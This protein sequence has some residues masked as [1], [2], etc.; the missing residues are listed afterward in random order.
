MRMTTLGF[1]NFVSSDVDPAGG[2]KVNLKDVKQSNMLLSYESKDYTKSNYDVKSSECMHAG[3][4]T[5]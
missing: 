2:V 5:T 1:C 3:N 4:Y